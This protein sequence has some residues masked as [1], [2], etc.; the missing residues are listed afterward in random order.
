MSKESKKMNRDNIR[1]GAMFVHIFTNEV[2]TVVRPGP[3]VKVLSKG[4]DLEKPIFPEQYKYYEPYQ[5]IGGS[6]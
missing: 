4:Y 5:V 6:L 1:E 2:V 3:F